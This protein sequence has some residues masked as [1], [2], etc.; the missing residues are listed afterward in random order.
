MYNIFYQARC[1][2]TLHNFF[3]LLQLIPPHLA[4]FLRRLLPSISCI[5]FDVHLLSNGVFGN[6]DRSI[7]PCGIICRDAM[8]VT[9][10]WV[11]HK[12]SSK[13]LWGWFVLVVYLILED[14]EELSHHLEQLL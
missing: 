14:I 7:A 11:C 12:W 3:L 1:V 5:L 6:H 8:G 4:L 9:V 10:F 13:E 2:Y